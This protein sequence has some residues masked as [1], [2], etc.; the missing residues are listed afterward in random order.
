MVRGAA[1]LGLAVVVLGL[2]GGCSCERE[3]AALR[4][5]GEALQACEAGATLAAARESS[6][7]GDLGRWL[8]L[9]QACETP[10]PG[11][12]CPPGVPGSQALREQAMAALGYTPPPDGLAM[13]AALAGRVLAALLPVALAVGLGGWAWARWAAPARREVEAARELIRTAR[14]QASEAESR[15]RAAEARAAQAEMEAEEAET[16]LAEAQARLA[17]AQ[18]EAARLEAA[19]RLLSGL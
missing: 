10:L 9:A 14:A 8:A 3:Q 18:A 19:R 1:A 2:L 7:A 13:W 17:E 15:R 16:R 5:V 12:P 4:E 6:L 11:L